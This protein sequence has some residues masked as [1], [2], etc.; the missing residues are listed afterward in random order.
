M[1]GD[2]DFDHMSEEINEY[3][4]H[5]N[6]IDDLFGEATEDDI[7]KITEIEVEGRKLFRR[8]RFKKYN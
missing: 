3:Y 1:S 7:K 4:K 8:L 6:L 2:Y 5:L